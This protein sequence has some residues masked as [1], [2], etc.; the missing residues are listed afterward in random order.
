MGCPMFL[1]VIGIVLV[2][3]LIVIILCKRMY[4][5]EQRMIAPEKS[6]EEPEK[7]EGEGA[8]KKIGAVYGSKRHWDDERVRNET[9]SPRRSRHPKRENPIGEMLAD[10]VLA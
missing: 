10:E 9:P 6:K 2:M 8:N 4:D 3:A 1:G 7:E 5:Q